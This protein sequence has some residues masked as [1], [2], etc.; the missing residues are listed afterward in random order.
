MRLFG[1]V[2]AVIAGVILLAAGALCSWLYCYTGDLPSIAGLDQ[3][4]PAAAAV[5]QDQGN[6][7]THVVPTDQLG[8]FLVSA[9]IAAEGQAEP[10]GPIHATVSDLLLGAQPHAQMYSWRLARELAPRGHALR[11]QID[12]LRLAE[13]IQRHFDQRQVITIYLNRVYLGEKIYGVEDGSLRY[14]GKHVSD[15][16]LEESALLVG[17]IRSP[18]HDSPIEHPERAVERR[19]WVVDQ[20]TSQ[21]SVTHEDAEHAKAAPLIVKRTANSEATYDWNR[22]A[23][24]IVSHVSPANTTIRVRA[25]EKST[26]YPPVIVY[27]VLESGEV[28]K[29]IVQRSSGIRDI[30]NYALAGVKTMRYE[31]RPPGCGVV[32]GEAVVTIDFVDH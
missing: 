14:F 21:G 15:L 23:L 16:S 10:R 17:L 28:Q 3:Y 31:E 4:S 9:V 7:L 12:E 19:N 26:K 32:A 29:A 27:E 13:Q 30:D 11:R 5:I 6:S 2:I 18:S 22:C 20:M 8:K 24:K 1:R 25:G